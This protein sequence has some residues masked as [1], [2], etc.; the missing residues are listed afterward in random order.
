MP[1]GFESEEEP[2]P[3]T[4]EIRL[5]ASGLDYEDKNH[6]QITI[7][8]EDA[9]QP[10]LKSTMKLDIHVQDVN[11]NAPIFDKSEYNV[12]LSESHLQGTPLLTIHAEDKDSGK[13]GRVTYSITSNPFHPC[14]HS[15]IVSMSFE[16]VS[17]HFP[18]GIHFNFKSFNF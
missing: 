3:E 14:L 2:S 4:G 17:D 9:G 16:D 7:E 10:V 13:N 5:V 11:D 6:H 18:I 15:P 8:A 1:P 12:A